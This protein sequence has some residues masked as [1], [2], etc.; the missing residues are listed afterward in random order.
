MGASQTPFTEWTVIES[1]PS[2]SG[3][4]DGAFEVPDAGVDERAAS[5]NDFH[6]L[7]HDPSSISS[8]SYTR[9]DNYALSPHVSIETS[10][11]EPGA[12]ARTNSTGISSSPYSKGDILSLGPEPSTNLNRAASNLGSEARSFVS[13]CKD[14]RF[15]RSRG[16]CVALE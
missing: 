11:V 6:D 10:P 16:R 14:C 1:S 15:L 3:R 4:C 12:S 2:S 8:A 5:G 9:R 7:A 13:S